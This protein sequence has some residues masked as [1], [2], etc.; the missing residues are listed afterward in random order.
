[1]LFEIFVLL[2]AFEWEADILFLPL[3]ASKISPP[4]FT[5]KRRKFFTPSRLSG[6]RTRPHSI[7][8]RRRTYPST[9]AIKK[10][11]VMSVLWLLSPAIPHLIA[12]TQKH[13]PIDISS[14]SCVKTLND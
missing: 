5:N 8:I 12:S 4:E 1:M 13:E 9:S 7:D 14:C 11:R 6:S 2:V 3:V 10:G